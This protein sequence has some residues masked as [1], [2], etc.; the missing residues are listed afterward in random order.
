MKTSWN[1]AQAIEHYLSGA[2]STAGALLFR[3][4]LLT[5]P[6]LRIKVAQQ[7]KAYALVQLYGR[8]KFKS[9]LE[10]MHQQ[11]FSDPEKKN[12]QQEV[13]QYFTKC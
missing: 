10:A 1:N 6:D 12:F 8:K 9:R 5:N 3:A 4:R 2:L 13:L 11:L 7:K